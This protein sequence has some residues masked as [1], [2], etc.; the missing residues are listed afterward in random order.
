MIWGMFKKIEL[1]GFKSFADR[2]EVDFSSG[3]TCIV[4]PNGCGKSNVSDA[5]RWV[6]GEQSSKALR[7][8]NMQ[9]VI[10]KGTQERG[11]LGYCEVSLHFDNTNKVFPVEYTDV[12][13]SRKLYRDGTSEYQINRQASRLKDINTLLHDSGIDRDG[14]TIIGQG[15]ISEIV[16]A[17]PES[18]RG[19]FEEAAG[20][21]KFRARKDEAERKFA[22]VDIEL[23][24]VAD[25]VAEIE[26]GLGTL[27]RQA[28]NARKYLELKGELKGLEINLFL[29]SYDNASAQKQE[30]NDKLNEIS[31]E[32]QSIQA[33]IEDLAERRTASMF[34]LNAIDKRAEDLRDKVLTLSLGLEKHSGE[35]KLSLEK[36]ANATAKQTELQDELSE[37]GERLKL[38]EHNLEQTKIQASGLRDVGETLRGQIHTLE[39]TYL[40]AKET[41]VKLWELKRQRERLMS[42]QETLAQ[43]EKGGFKHAVRRLVESKDRNRIIADNM[44]GVIADMLHVPK[45][46]EV[47]IDVALGAGS[48][49][50]IVRTED[51]AKALVNLLKENKWGR[52]TFLPLTSAKVRGWSEN[53][54]FYFKERGVMGVASDLI[55]Y[56]H[57]IDRAVQSLL[58]RIVI[59]D[60]IDNAVALAKR[61]NY[62]FR[63]VTVD[64]DSIETRGS[65]S[66]GSKRE[67]GMES[68]VGELKDLD[69]RI[70]D[71][72]RGADEKS[73]GEDLVAL[74]IQAT[75]TDS[76]LG[77][78]DREY[79]R[80]ESLIDTIQMSITDKNDQLAKIERAMEGIDKEDFELVKVAVEKLEAAKANLVSLDTEKEALKIT[81]N[82]LEEG[83]DIAQ[84]NLAKAHELYY[85]T[86]AKLENIDLELQKLQ[87]RIWEEYELN[88]SACYH[89]KVEEFDME[90]AR[91]RIAELRR[92]ITRLGSVNLDA[93]EQSAEANERFTSYTTQMNDLEAA[94]ADLQKVIADLAKEM[95][96]KFR[97]TFNAINGHFGSVF[98]ELFG[99]GRAHLEMTNPSDY[100]NSGI[101]I[102]AEPTGKKLQNI[103]LLSGGEKSMTAIAL[104]FAI[105]K[106]KP[107]PFVLLDEVEAALDEVNVVRFAS[108]LKNFSKN[109]QFIVITHRKPTMELGD[110]LYGVTM[111]NR[112]VSKLVSVSLADWAA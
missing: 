40:S 95:E 1:Y 54:R 66:G 68:L 62:S 42:R 103:Q 77:H 76:E 98:K 26:R 29:H 80:L 41:S 10:F 34:A 92:A 46:L 5:I 105:L 60:N 30:I 84:D 79:D 38:E 78:L 27:L 49:N 6:L 106:V 48:Q 112:G 17:R 104:L 107:M 72:D 71:L 53:E 50:V 8:S 7:G 55:E 97:E 57:G 43:V 100:L 83:R 90:T 45:G 14:L 23:V 69:R 82:E 102:I 51:N 94:K 32:I 25:V 63:I 44:L 37:L 99:G 67:Q 59:V 12:V 89:M 56:E 109:T 81:I 33:N 28:E 16:A 24:R 20:I 35:Q 15:Q 2:L 108:Y 22:N 19:I 47:A 31:D 75:S 11:R 52:A 93:I 70:A 87:E 91:G 21:A 4:G 3:I 73:I 61:S 85:K 65:I 18:R 74:R 111:E 36:A 86:Q 39:K 64:G 101:D 96:T 110:H 13:L 9:D 58:G 88:Y